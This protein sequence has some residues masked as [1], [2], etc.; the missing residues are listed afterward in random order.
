MEKIQNLIIGFGKGGKTLAKSLAAKGEEVV[1]I[2]KDAQM[3][4]GTRINVGCIPS[5]TLITQGIKKRTFTVAAQNKAA[6]INKLRN[7]NYHMLAD[8]VNIQVINGTAQFVSNHQVAVRTVENEEVVY[9][10]QRIFINTGVQAVI[11]KV[12]GLQL[13]EK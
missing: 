11:P 8:D 6:L 3:Y 7:K 13:S 5:K 1:V 12:T 4:G 2:Q 9:E 10:A